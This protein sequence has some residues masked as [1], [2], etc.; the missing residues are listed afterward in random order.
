M[1]RGTILLVEDEVVIAL[2]MESRLAD[3]GYAVNKTVYSG[4]DAVAVVDECEPDIILMDI[5][6]SKEMDGIHAARLI[7]RRHDVPIIY[8]T[9]NA[10]A[11]TVERAR[12]TLPYGYLNK[13]VDDRDL[14]TT[15]DSALHIHRMEKRLRQSEEK[16]RSLVEDISDMVYTVDEYGH[17]TYISP[18]VKELFQYSPEELM[19][20]N[21]AEYI[22]PDDIPRMKESIIKIMAGTR[23]EPHEYRFAARSGEYRWMRASSRSITAGGKFA[24]F[25]GVM[26][27]ISA[28]KLADQ[29]LHRSEQR[30]RS[31]IEQA[32]DEI[33]VHGMDGKLIDVNR[34]ACENLGYSRE[35][36][37]SLTVWDV[38]PDA[39]GREDH[40]IFWPN[41]PATFEAR[42]KKKDGSVYDVEVRLGLIEI[43]D[44]NLVLA[45]VHDITEQKKNA[46]DLADSERKYR[47]VVDNANDLILVIRDGV[48][49]FIS[50]RALELTGYSQEELAGRSFLEYIHPEDH[51]RLIDAYRRNL[52]GE[53]FPKLHDYRILHRDGAA[54]WVI[55]SG[56]PVDWEG[57]PA[58]LYFLTDITEHKRAEETMKAA[59]REKESLLR[60]VHHRV[61]NNLQVVMSMLNLQSR[62]E[63]S[64]EAVSKFR[65]CRDRINAMALVHEHLYGA[66]NLSGINFGRYLKLLARELHGS[67]RGGERKI[68]LRVQAEEIELDIARAVPCGLMANE[69]ITNAL[70]HAFPEG[71]RG[72]RAIDISFERRGDHLLLVIA[73]NGR[74]IPP[75]AEKGVGGSLGLSLVPLMASQAAGSI[76]LDRTSGTRFTIRLES[77]NDPPAAP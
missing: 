31:I 28:V 71:H 46:R 9:A 48:I 27:D 70:K 72:D 38:D 44:E 77:Q 67:Y 65:E 53:Q 64:E 56:S 7:R 76:E 41:L 58:M 32:A 37:L 23:N 45:I 20:K 55:V 59:L 16:Y 42:H 73:D 63:S 47:M 4:E 61:K 49:R 30:F 8:M 68:A 15:L 39:G 19:G 33:F 18:V 69:L 43:D 12:D 2:D 6:L 74:G 54:R 57:A 14:S 17:I 1:N 75:G 10:D 29:R 40:Q 66:E 22:H 24:G 60:E 36:L 26:T 21:F 13:P 51:E 25:R 34:A 11:A 3:M 5:L 62:R 50:P 52:E 35:E